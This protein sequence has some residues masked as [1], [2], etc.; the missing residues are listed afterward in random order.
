MVRE[1][2]K[3]SECLPKLEKLLK[4]LEVRHEG[5]NMEDVSCLLLFSEGF[6]QPS[7]VTCDLPASNLALT[8]DILYGVHSVEY[9]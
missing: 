3:S 5:G 6:T 8:I 9:M 4:T 2:S 7:S 1:L